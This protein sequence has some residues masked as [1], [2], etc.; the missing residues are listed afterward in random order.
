MKALN[1]SGTG[2]TAEQEGYDPRY[3]KDLNKSTPAGSTS[4]G[5]F[6]SS[7]NFFGSMQVKPSGKV[8]FNSSKTYFN[9]TSSIRVKYFSGEKV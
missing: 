3:E 9:E 6:N 7:K 4:E 8:D 1:E 5:K 2:P